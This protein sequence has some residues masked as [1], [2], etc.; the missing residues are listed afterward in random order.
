MVIIKFYDESPEEPDERK[1]GSTRIHPLESSLD[2]PPAGVYPYH[3]EGPNSL[4][5]LSDGPRT[6]PPAG[7]YPYHGENPYSFGSFSEELDK[8]QE[9]LGE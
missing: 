6:I 7:E 4:G 1:A 5:P 2:I 8:Q 9:E 3:G